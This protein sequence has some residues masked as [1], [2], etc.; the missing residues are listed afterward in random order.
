MFK[1]FIIILLSTINLCY[2]QKLEQPQPLVIVDKNNFF[3]GSDDD[4]GRV[5]FNEFTT[6]KKYCKRGTEDWDDQC[7]DAV[8]H[9]VYGENWRE[10]KYVVLQFVS[11]LQRGDSEA[12]ENL[13]GALIS[14][15][16]VTI[17]EISLVYRDGKMKHSTF[18]STNKDQFLHEF[19]K[20]KRL[21]TIDLLHNCFK[22]QNYRFPRLN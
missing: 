15:A 3:K 14:G 11:A 20:D 19:Q 1:L 22:A 12:I 16:T 21:L 5:I 18:I 6:G 2:A 9:H 7:Q 17:F 13:C 4:P 10:F 8:M